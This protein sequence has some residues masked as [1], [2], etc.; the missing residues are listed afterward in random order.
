MISKGRPKRCRFSRKASLINRLIRFRSTAPPT[1]RL[2]VIPIRERPLLAGATKTMKKRVLSRRPVPD[3]AI[4]SVRFRMRSAFL[5]KKRKSSV[6]FNRFGAAQWRRIS[7]R[8]WR[9]LWRACGSAPC[10][11]PWWPYVYGTRDFWLDAVGWVEMVFSW[12][13]ILSGLVK[14][15]PLKA[16]R[17][18]NRFFGAIRPACSGSTRTQRRGC[19][20]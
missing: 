14:T 16:A 20:I 4:N 17:R 1:L 15:A 18:P 13:H 11:R 19:M 12:S 2:T 8:A 5:R 9:G 3:N 7:P 6:A 10:G